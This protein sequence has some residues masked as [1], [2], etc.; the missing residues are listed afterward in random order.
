M[1]KPLWIGLLA[2]AL[3][4]IAGLVWWQSASYDRNEKQLQQQLD[5]EHQLREKN[6]P[7]VPKNSSSNIPSRKWSGEMIGIYL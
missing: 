4:G 3:L 2:A 7:Y 6:L 5:R 1:S